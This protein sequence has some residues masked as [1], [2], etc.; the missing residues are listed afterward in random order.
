MTSPPPSLNVTGS[1]PLL[2]LVPGMDG[3]GLLFY[4]QV[5]L[6]ARY[7]T[8]VTYGL[9]HTATAM[10]TLVAD[11]DALIETLSPLEPRAILVGESFGGA[12]AMSYALAH[13]ERVRT[14]VV[15]NSFPYF[16]PQRRLRVGSVLLRLLPVGTMA[17]VR[18][19]TAF[20]LYSAHTHRADV[21][22]F[23]ELAR[24]TTREGYVNRLH[25]LRTYDVRARLAEIAAPT[26]LLA[27]DADHLVPSVAQAKLMAQLLP[28]AVVRVLAGHGHICLIAPDLDL[29]A[30]L[31]DWQPQLASP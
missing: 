29:A 10:D 14:L 19:L 2:V 5:P 3:T 24:L 13:P 23:R 7:F 20:R 6:L 22:R 15:L 16:G 21:A 17:L 28:G 1:G 18:Q 11:L 26:L 12:L 27:A 4:R 31:L 30:I 25:I 8:V 9:R